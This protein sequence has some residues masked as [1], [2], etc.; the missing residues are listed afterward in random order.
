VRPAYG[1]VVEIDHGHGFRTRYAHLKDI[2]VQRG[3][4]LAI[5]Q[6]LG[7]MGSTG[8]STGTHLHYEVWFRGKTYDPASFLRAGQHVHE[9]G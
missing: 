9:Q 8:R 7:S 2:Q 6:R 3:E 4:K 5:G 1:Y